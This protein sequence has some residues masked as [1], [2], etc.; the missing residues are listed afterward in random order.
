VFFFV[1][2]ENRAQQAVDES[3]WRFD[4]VTQG[5]TRVAVVEGV[6]LNGLVIFNQFIGGIDFQ[7]N[8]I[9]VS[10]PDLRQTEGYI[11][12]PNITFG[13]NTPITWISTIVEAHDLVDTGGQLELLYSDNP[14]AILDPNH[15]TWL[16]AQRLSSQGASNFEAPFLNLKSRTLSLQLK[17]KASTAQSVSPKV[18][19]IA[20]RGIPA[21]R[22]LIMLVPFNVSDIVSAPG[23]RPIRVPGLGD[24]LHEQVLSLVGSSIEAIVLD[25]PVGFRGVVNNI[26]EPVE[27]VSD[28]GSVT[29]YVTVEFRGQRRTQTA[30]PTGDAGM[31][32]GLMGIAII[33]IGQSEDT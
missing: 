9:L 17:I 18:T 30:A 14:Q 28:R 2:E 24:S 13:L 21:H 20:L 4:I 25:P 3:L 6:N 33:G 22:D 5:L 8:T 32:L 26:S 10:D 15:P 31:G 11:I 19:R 16:V 7:S 12:F 29:R 1:K 27:F 23:R